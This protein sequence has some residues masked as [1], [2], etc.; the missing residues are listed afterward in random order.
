MRQIFLHGLG[1]GPDSWEEVIS[2]LEDKPTCLDLYS[3]FQIGR[4][5][6]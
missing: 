1:Q 2:S 5:H 3:F 4:A 6:V